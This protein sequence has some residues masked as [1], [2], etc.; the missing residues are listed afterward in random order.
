[1][2]QHKFEIRNDQF[3]VRAYTTGESAGNS[4]DTR[5]A[6]INLNRSWKSDT[7]WFTEYAGA[8][9]QTYVGTLMAGGTP[10]PAAIHQSARA[11]A[12]KEL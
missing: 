4:Y 10:D 12:Q 11:I 5:F 8:Y 2:F 1:M 3:F 9:V 6:A 7:Q